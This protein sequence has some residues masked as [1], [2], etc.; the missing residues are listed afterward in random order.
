M[1]YLAV[2]ILSLSLAA[3][4]STSALPPAPP[5]VPP[6]G[7]PSTGPPDPNAPPAPVPA[8]VP[9]QVS[10]IDQLAANPL[11]AAVQKDANDTIAWV[12]SPDGPTDTLSKFQALQCPTAI[13]LTI[14][15]VQQELQIL[16]G[17]IAGMQLGQSPELILFFTKLRYGSAATSGLDIAGLKTK[18]GNQ[19]TAVF[20]SCMQIFPKKQ[21][22]DAANI[23]AK[24]GIS[25]TVPGAGPLLA[26]PLGAIF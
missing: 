19:V 20:A 18:I 15:S 13:N 25:V 2:C 1:R 9:P 21:M 26:G 4:A 10:A 3:C 23:A 22:I 6:V 12:N 16:K 17:L 14:A 8:P 24:A 5:D 7:T 11:I